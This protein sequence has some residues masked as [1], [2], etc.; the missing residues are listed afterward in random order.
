MAEDEDELLRLYGGIDMS[1]H[2][3]VFTALFN[4]VSSFPSSL[5]LLSV[6]QALLLLGPERADI[7]QALESLTNRAILI[8]QNSEMDSCE[9]IL[10]R[11]VFAKESSKGSYE[12]DN[13]QLK[14]KNQAI[15]TEAK[16]EK[17]VC[18][19]GSAKKEPPR[20]STNTTSTPPPSLSSRSP[21]S[22]SAVPHKTGNGLPPPPPLLPGAGM[23]A[24]PPPPPPL[25]G[26]GAAPPLTGFGAPPPPPPLPGFGAPPPP[27]PLS[28]F[29][30]PPPPPP[31]S[32][33]G[34]PPP[35][36]PLP[37]FG[38]QSFPGFGAPPPPPPLPG[39]GA[40]PPPPLPGFGAPP[41]PPPPLP[42][43][44]APPPAFG[45]PPPPPLP[46]MGAPPPL[47][48]P[49]MGDV[50]V[51]QR[52]HPVGHY[53]SAPVRSGP[54]PTLR[55]KKL[56][57]QK[58][59][60]RAV[61]D[62]PSMW[63]SVPSESPLEPNYSSIEQLFCLPV[64]E[65]KD[66]SPAAPLKKEPKEISFIDPKKNLNLN[67]FLKQFRCSNEDFVAMVQKG[68]CSKFD[69]ES[70]K[71]LLKL[72]PE[73]HEI[74]NLKSFQ[75][76]Q[77]KLANVDQLYL[78][79][80]ALPCY[81]LRIECMLL[82]EETLSVLDILKPKVELVETACESLRQSSLLP[83]FCKLILDVG[84]FLNYGSHTGN[85]DGFKIG[86]LLKLT[87]TKAN[88][89]RITL[90]HHILEEAELNHPELLNLPEEIAP[91][92]KAA[93][94]NLDSIQ[95][96]IGN[97]LKRLKDAEKKVSLSVPDVK[98]QFLGVIESKRCACESLEQRFSIMDSK[99]GA[100]AQYLCE[101][102][103][104][105]SLDELFSTIKTFRELFIRALKE[106]RVRKEQAA[107]A[108]K[109]KQQLAEEES[110]RQKGEDGKII[111]RGPVPQDDGCIIDQLLAD[112]RKGFHLRKTRP[113]CEKESP[114]REKQSRDAE[115]SAS[116]GGKA[117]SSAVGESAAP[118]CTPENADKSSG[119][120]P[121]GEDTLSGNGK[122]KTPAP[123]KKETDIRA[124]VTTEI[125]SEDTKEINS[126]I[127]SGLN[128]E[129]ATKINSEISTKNKSDITKE[130]NP[131]ITNEINCGIIKEIKPEISTKNKSD[132]TKE[133]NPKIT[134]EINSGINSEISTKNKSDITKEINPK[135]TNEI[136]SGINSEISTKNKSDITKEI[137]PKI[138][139][140]INSGIDSEISTKNKSDITKEINP[141]I[142]NEINSGIDS[143]ISTKNKSDI[144]KETNPEITNKINSE[145]TTKLDSEFTTEINSEIG[146]EINSGITSE[147]NSGITKKINS[148]SATKFNSEFATEIISGITKEINFEIIKE[149]KPE[150]ATKINSRIAK[151]VNSEIATEINSNVMNSPLKS[152]SQEE[153]AKLSGL[154][155]TDLHHNHNGNNIRSNS[156]AET[157][158]TASSGSKVNSSCDST[159]IKTQCFDDPLQSTDDQPIADV[160]DG[161][162]SPA[163]PTLDVDHVP[164]KAP[165]T[166]KPFFQRSS[167]KGSN[168]GNSR[169]RR[170]KGRRKS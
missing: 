148:D 162:M 65:P 25:P 72:L 81:Q 130:I 9:K 108:E 51:A 125:K 59:N 73:K 22:P 53:S 3:E 45:A 75:G 116:A 85:A 13:F 44:G 96:E 170:T 123:G 112:I 106:N 63:A 118:V 161:V 82:C 35:P 11:L 1:N 14:R 79:L 103:A 57:W 94:I 77:D 153:H 147:I 78:L 58:L 18:S 88:K 126:K 107:K 27:P 6:L 109:R 136:N 80:L 83:S 38:A 99:R 152:S 115:A 87:E 133:I 76:E 105:L 141:K 29:G 69:V 156:A 149:I 40:P 43:M 134:N 129:I 84:N 8:A 54:Y 122:L 70:L 138:T 23:S 131:E 124:D 146:K 86:S 102:A 95:A 92:E 114:C 39:F 28:G 90:L 33:F 159:K 68:D 74:D 24:P 132:I 169:K 34:A 66:K 30:A 98:E 163:T 142:T 62:G 157:V 139:N 16:D 21:P 46:G 165:E 127:K 20:T 101:D 41:P 155:N 97:L 36:P 167:K 93:G 48:P 89:S 140:E 5:Q 2:Q 4:K 49:G 166:K 37:G 12:V 150:I 31:L 151:E 100:L 7:W 56:N 50:I 60:S 145:I 52:F 128:S 17:L 121:T 137:N 168:E 144:T 91:C 64:S 135:I 110:K 26:L 15:Q 164:L 61:T 67:I 10:Q 158:S 111:R 42:G 120:N 55:M 19:C 47:P 71:Q 154:T 119:I 143:E 32:V 104:Q 117:G 113:R 160:P